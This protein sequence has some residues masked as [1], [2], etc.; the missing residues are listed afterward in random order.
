M[1]LLEQEQEVLR[2]TGTENGASDGAQ[3][4]GR[5]RRRNGAIAC[6]QESQQPSE[7]EEV[8]VHP[9]VLSIANISDSVRPGA[10]DNEKRRARDSN[11]Q[12][13]SRH[14][15]SSEAAH[16]FAYPPADISDG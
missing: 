8:D 15:I 7:S 16:Q 10:S 13:V 1:K 3:Q 9:N 2:A 14:L 4:S 11:P 5:E 6:D 12:P